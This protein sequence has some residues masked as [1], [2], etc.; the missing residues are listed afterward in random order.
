MEL[1]NGTFGKRERKAKKNTEERGGI[2]SKQKRCIPIRLALKTFAINQQSCALPAHT[3]LTYIQQS[4]NGMD[5]TKKHP[6]RTTN[7]TTNESNLA[8]LQVSNGQIFLHRQVYP[9]LCAYH[10]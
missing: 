10:G 4:I 8:G 5:P 3:I 9:D 1:D 7:R 2:A 6:D